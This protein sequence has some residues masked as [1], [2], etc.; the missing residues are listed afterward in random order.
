M[1]HDDQKKYFEELAKEVLSSFV[2]SKFSL[3][4]LCDKP[5][6]QSIELKYGIEVTRCMQKEDGIFDFFIREYE[7]KPNLEIDLNQKIKELK[8]DCVLW[9]ELHAVLCHKKI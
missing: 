1:G 3:L 8:L 6:L 5:D 4:Q 7:E 9:P 2:D